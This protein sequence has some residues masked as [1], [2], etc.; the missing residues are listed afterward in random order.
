[1]FFRGIIFGLQTMDFLKSIVSIRS[2]TCLCVI[3][4]NQASPTHTSF[5]SPTTACSR[6]LAGICANACAA[7][8]TY[9]AYSEMSL[10][11]KLQSVPGGQTLN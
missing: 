11:R 1:M 3:P 4:I 9:T 2:I 10:L 8:F 6:Y 5:L 7:G